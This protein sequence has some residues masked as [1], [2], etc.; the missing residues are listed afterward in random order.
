MKTLI[1]SGG[2]IAMLPLI[3]CAGYAV[4][5]DHLANSYA[6]IRAAE[7]TGAASSPDAALHL[8]IAQEEQAKAKAL[9]A[10]DKNEEADFMTMRANADAEL[11]IAEAREA[12]AR[13]AAGRMNKDIAAASQNSV[14]PQSYSATATTTTTSTTVPTTPQN[15]NQNQGSQAMPNQG[16]QTNQGSA[17]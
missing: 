11:A 17:K 2:I 10:D 9:I 3:G 15:L 1:L 14:M 16:S 12:G 6:N 7:A 13:V 5:N 4:P 8:R